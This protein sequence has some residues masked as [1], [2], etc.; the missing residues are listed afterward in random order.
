MVAT[1]TV[2]VPSGWEPPTESDHL[3]LLLTDIVDSTAVNQAVGDAAMALLWAEHDQRSR[4]LAARWGGREIGRSDGFLMLFANVDD[5]VGFAGDYQTF[6]RAMMPPLAARVGIHAGPGVLRFNSDADRAR[7]ATPFE[8]DGA[9]LPIAARVMSTATGGQTLLSAAAFERL[10]TRP[11]HVRSHGHWSLKGV[12]EPMML[13]EVGQADSPFLPPADSEKSYRVVWTRD[14]W[15]PRRGVANSLP[16]D[17]D[18]FIGRGLALKTLADKF[19]AGARLVSALGIGGT[20]KTRLATRF[21]WLHLG[22][23]PG[24]VWFCDLSSARAIEDIAR[25]VAQGLQVPLGG[26]EPVAQLSAVLAS[27][28]PCLLILDNFEQ[29]TRFAEGTVGRWLNGAPAVKFLVTTREVLGIAGEDVLALAPLSPGE[30]TEL[31]M[32]RAAAMGGDR[33]ES[34]HLRRDV[35]RLVEL[36]DGLPL[37][38]ELAAAR[39]LV[40]SPSKLLEGMGER[41]KLL[42]SRGGRQDRQSTLRKT[43]DWSWE[44]LTGVEKS[45]LA[46]LSVFEGGVSAAAAESV[47]ELPAEAGSLWLADLLQSLVEKSMLRVQSDSRFE[48]LSTLQEYAA[49]HLAS[50]GHFPDSGPVF[51]A[52]TRSRHCRHFAQLSESDAVADR[53]V[54]LANLLTACRRAVVDS[55]GTT[56]VGAL[57][58]SW[59]ALKLRGPFRV[60]LELADAVNAGCKLARA[61]DAAVQ[62]VAGSAL[63]SMGKLDLAKERLDAG[64]VAAREGGD[65]RNA[66]RLLCS[67][68]EWFSTTGDE[69]AAHRYLQEAMDLSA[70][71]SDPLVQLKALNELGA[72][73]QGQL[74]I[75]ESRVL[76]E[77][78]LS[79][80]R[81]LGDVRWEGAVLGNLGG[82]LHSQDR[83]DEAAGLYESAIARSQ[84]CGDRRMEGNNRC[85]LGLLLHE[86]GRHVEA[87]AQFEV[88]LATARDLGNPRLESTALCNLGL[89]LESQ[90]LLADALSHQERAA[91][92]A[93][94]I[95]DRRIEGQI[96]TC[97]GRLYA[98]QG[99]SERAYES[100]AAGELCFAQTRDPY[101]LALLL[102]E[103]AEL[104][105]LDGEL[106][107]AETAL[108]RA[109]AEVSGHPVDSRV[110]VDQALARCRGLV[111]ARR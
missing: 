68:G 96:R 49:E 97:L 87:V 76:Y 17:R 84:R 2:A 38:I 9:A 102:C 79:L 16:V 57:L 47:L 93:A 3:V 98:K 111:T 107:G 18:V 83:L 103:L 10:A 74:K 13:F 72:L 86:R 46:Q 63:Y 15:L 88:V 12:H 51:A 42:A 90:Q 40:M 44:L 95:G 109:E 52:Q 58:R 30:G 106:S 94:Q 89:A 105:V 8:L 11:P 60:G 22:D 100:F 39:T 32:H 64:L 48:L 29:V 65:P 77:R 1:Q 50:A 73:A 99:S 81:A 23:Y 67:L 20:G 80:A 70:T 104:C 56:A 5:A 45:V 91:S 27:R 25:A 53:C 75:G 4:A 71:A 31:F 7:G 19:S 36:L 24:G 59:A 14:M 101:E 54:E 28:E 55:D 66:A 82:L 21:G 35:E 92:I 26:Q 37:A 61:D 110:R 33:F 69:E 85:N 108:M 6:T 78:A 62:W 41:F 43:F 34:R